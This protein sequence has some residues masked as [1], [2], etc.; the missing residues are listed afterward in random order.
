MP[1]VDHQS[2][3]ITTQPAC[4]CCAASL[5]AHQHCGANHIRKKTALL[6]CAPENFA[7][8]LLT[9]DVM[10]VCRPVTVSSRDALPVI[11]NRFCVLNFINFLRV[12]PRRKRISRP[13]P[14]PP[15]PSLRRHS[16]G[17]T[18]TDI[19]RAT[20]RGDWTFGM[21]CACGN[22]E[23][24]S[25]LPKRDEIPNAQQKRKRMRGDMHGDCALCGGS[26]AHGHLR[27]TRAIA[28]SLPERLVAPARRR[29]GAIGWPLL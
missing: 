21:R 29:G 12:C 8:A 22:R 14:P 18:P 5:V 17:F 3:L 25:L 1:F 10:P 15:P 23:A 7:L 28:S 13:H 24:T 11:Y 20:R 2:H 27:I 16:R 4:L 6:T 26:Q 19:S 9:G